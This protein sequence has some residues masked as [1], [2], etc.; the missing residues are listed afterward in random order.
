MGVLLFIIILLA[1]RLPRLHFTHEMRDGLVVV[2]YVELPLT[3]TND[4]HSLIFTCSMVE[5]TRR[6]L[7][8][9]NSLILARSVKSCVM[10]RNV[11]DLLDSITLA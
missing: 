10:L 11:S 8:I 6:V 2:T 1:V 7:G 4:E 9:V 3:E 5:R